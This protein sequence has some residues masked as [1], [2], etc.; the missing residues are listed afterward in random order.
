MQQVQPYIQQ[1][2][3]ITLTLGTAPQQRT[4]NLKDLEQRILDN[5]YAHLY[6][7]GIESKLTPT[8][9]TTPTVVGHNSSTSD[10]E[11]SDG[12]DVLFKGQGNDLRMF[13]R[14]ENGGDLISEVIQTTST[15]PR[16][17]RRIIELGPAQLQGS[18]IDFARP[19]AEFVNGYLKLTGSALTDISADC[20]AATL[21]YRVYA[22]M[23][24][25]DELRFPAKY[26]RQVVANG[27]TG[28][29]IVGQAAY[30]FLGAVKATGAAGYTAFAAGDFGR[31]SVRTGTMRPVQNVS[32]PVLT[33]AYNQSFRRGEVSPIAG[34][35]NDAT[36]DVNWRQVNLTSPTALAAQ[37]ADL[38]ALLW[39]PPDTQL[40][41]LNARVAEQVIVDFSGSLGANGAYLV[42]RFLPMTGE[43]ANKRAG[44]VGKALG[45]STGTPYAKTL[46]GKALGSHPMAQYWTYAVKGAG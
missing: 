44:K 11:F 15:N 2:D 20:T 17:I 32:A 9:T 29:K 23:M 30:A 10:I 18:P 16:W 13:E 3:D 41:K 5:K 19:C 27:G 28:T 31:V 34:E 35:P 42:G 43:Q 21:V 37:T 1:L 33:G 8:F 14:L 39:C 26:Q 4:I 7:L 36:F 6:A 46:G 12:E 38:Q 40:S 24:P 25:S 22:Y 45:I